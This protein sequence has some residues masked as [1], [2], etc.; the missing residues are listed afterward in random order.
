[1]FNMRF[2]VQFFTNYYYSQKFNSVLFLIYVQ[3]FL[4]SHHARTVCFAHMSIFQFQFQFH[5]TIIAWPEVHTNGFAKVLVRKSL[6]F[7]N[8][9]LVIR[10]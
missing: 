7:K 4:Q 1:M 2:P 3:Q 8:L 10:I 5:Y 9:I 6:E